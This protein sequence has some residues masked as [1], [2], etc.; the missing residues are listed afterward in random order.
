MPPIASA[1]TVPSGQRL[2]LCSISDHYQSDRHVS[3]CS[4]KKK[5]KT[6]KKNAVTADDVNWL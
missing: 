6:K 1:T 2:T 4:G 5:Q 3:G